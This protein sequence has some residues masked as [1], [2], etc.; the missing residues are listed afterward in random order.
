MVNLNNHLYDEKRHLSKEAQSVVNATTA[1]FVTGFILGGI[2]KA[3]D[4]PETYK[5]EN[6]ATVYQHKF[7]AYREIQYKVTLSLIKGGLS[8]ALKLGTFCFLFSSISAIFY[9]Y[10]GKFDV[11]SST[12]SGA[13]TGCLYKINMGLKGAFAGTL[14][15]S[16][17]GTIY[18]ISTALIL[19]ITGVEMDE[20][21]ET[22]KLFPSTRREKI[23][24]Q[25]RKLMAD[26]KSELQMLYEQKYAS[27]NT[28]K[29]EE[30]Q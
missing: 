9:I 28:I 8:F 7:D 20:L 11:I 2:A 3:K 18:G 21:Y 15:G 22:G 1:G 23:R 12:C 6:Q 14:L 16:I 13:I 24:E 29:N 25:T 19:F 10:K 5:A 17:L 27:V 4:V 26:E 30:K